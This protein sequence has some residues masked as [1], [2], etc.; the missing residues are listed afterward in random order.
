MLKLANP[1][2][3]VQQ[4]WLAYEKALKE[5]NKT[6][7]ISIEEGLELTEML[8]GVQAAASEIGPEGLDAVFDLIDDFGRRENLPLEKIEAMKAAFDEINEKVTFDALTAELQDLSSTIFDQKIQVQVQA[9][10]PTQ[11]EIQQAVIDAIK[12]LRRNR[13]GLFSGSE[14]PT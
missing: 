12:G 13:P 7:G 5:A 8:A 4:D 6:G 9:D 1:V 11:T 2:F 10:L 14:Q 3:A